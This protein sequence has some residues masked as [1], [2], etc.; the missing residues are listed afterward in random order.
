MKNTL[1]VL[2]GSVVA[3]ASLWGALTEASAYD[4]KWE[5]G[6]VW[7][8]QFAKTK[9]GKFN[10]YVTDLSNVYR[11]YADR[12]VKDGVVLSYRILEVSFP[13]DNEPDIMVLTEY[14]DMQVFDR[15]AA[16]F[17]KVIEEVLGSM[18]EA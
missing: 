17:D 11:K 18:T 7:T 9:P 2:I 15:G 5:E 12:L 13:R 4:R 3:V 8:I 10:S 6:T 16:Y 14:K 1:Q